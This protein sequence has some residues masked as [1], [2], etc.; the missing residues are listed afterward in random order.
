MQLGAVMCREVATIQSDATLQEA[1]QVMAAHE[2][3][4][5]TVVKNDVP[6]GVITAWDIAV[7]AT[8]NGFDPKRARVRC[9]MTTDLVCGCETYDVGEAVSLLKHTH[10]RRLP[11]LDRGRRLVG[12]VS[13]EDLA[14]KS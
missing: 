9:A 2:V 10:L 11:V 7:R 12:I 4:L 1:A 3:E 5:L 14:S 13:V 8:A 6:I